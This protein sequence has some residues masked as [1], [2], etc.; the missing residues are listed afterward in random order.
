MKA[1]QS[2]VHPD[3]TYFMIGT[4]IIFLLNC[5]GIGESHLPHRLKNLTLGDRLMVGQEPL[6]LLI[7]VRFQVPQHFF[8]SFWT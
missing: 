8:A 2:G 3:A 6:K 1:S 5:R 7:L 4:L